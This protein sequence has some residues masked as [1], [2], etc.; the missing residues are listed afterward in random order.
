[1][2]DECCFLEVKFKMKEVY[3]SVLPPLTG[4]N[5]SEICQDKTIK[6]IVRYELQGY[7]VSDGGKVHPTCLS[8]ANSD[9]HGCT[10]VMTMSSDQN[11]PI[12][13]QNLP[14]PCSKLSNVP[15]C[16]QTS[17]THLCSEA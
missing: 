17:N 15:I 4:K 7:L 16:S 8:N 5:E 13:L 14:K 3:I 6:I 2:C 1:M 9:G 12:C 10:L 11:M